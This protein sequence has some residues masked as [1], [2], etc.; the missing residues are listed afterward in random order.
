MKSN[1]YLVAWRQYARRNG[2]WLCFRRSRY[3]KLTGR[4]PRPI[5]WM[6]RL[7][8]YPIAGAY[9]I[10]HTLAFETWPHFIWSAR[11]PARAKEFVPIDEKAPRWVPPLLFEGRVQT[12]DGQT[13]DLEE[14]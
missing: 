13:I 14:P 4:I 11:P 1:C 6:A 2:V 8:M 7:L 3:S 5:R 9:A 10:L 12:L